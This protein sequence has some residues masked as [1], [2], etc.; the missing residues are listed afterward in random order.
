MRLSYELSLL[1]VD[2]DKCD[3]FYE[4]ILRYFAF[5]LCALSFEFS[6]SQLVYMLKCMVRL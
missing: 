6:K 4:I 3:R 5:L 2:V 1:V